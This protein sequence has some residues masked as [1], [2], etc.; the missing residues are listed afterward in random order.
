[1]NIGSA[2]KSVQNFAARN[3][4]TGDDFGSVEGNRQEASRVDAEIGRINSD[5]VDIQGKLDTLRE[6]SKLAPPT[7]SAV[8]NKQVLMGTTSA[9]AVVGGAVGVL[10]N[11]AG[12]GSEVQIHERVVPIVEQEI[13][14]H[15]FDLKF[16][17]SGGTG[18]ANPDG[19]EVESFSRRPLINKE[20]G[21]YTERSATG[22]AGNIAVSGLIGA[23][24][25]AGVGA[26]AGL[27]VVGL[28]KALGKDYDGTPARET[29][30]DKKL[31]IAGGV[32]GAVVGG[33]A[34]ALSAVVNSTSVSYE[35]QSIPAMETK[36]LGHMPSGPGFYVPVDQV[37][38]NPLTLTEDQMGAQTAEWT[39]WSQDKLVNRGFSSAQ[40]LR[41]QEIRGQVPQ[42]GVLGGL[43]IN[44]EDKEVN[45]GPGMVPSVLGG[46]AVGAVTGVAGGVLVNVLRKTL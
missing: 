16:Y 30:G 33:A 18:P 22:S 43:K 8:S 39:Q 35:T 38:G 36:V 23:G 31:L 10:S 28:R 42:R 12:G 15:G 25:G 34:G 45:V 9:G 32:A 37:D 4:A 40:N 13:N 6:D 14:G 1:M 7:F 5:T 26:A 3:L 27:G 44:T 29:E 24:I 20:V 41:P 2:F 21:S 11:L 17:T 46:M 19:Y